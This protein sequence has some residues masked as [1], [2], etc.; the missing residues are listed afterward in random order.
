LKKNDWQQKVKEKKLRKNKVDQMVNKNS[1]QINAII[2]RKS[3]FCQPKNK[4]KQQSALIFKKNKNISS[5]EK[6]IHAQGLQR[7][8]GMDLRPLRKFELMEEKA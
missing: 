8:E 5:D 3:F 6:I 2:H 7:G 4:N 1:K